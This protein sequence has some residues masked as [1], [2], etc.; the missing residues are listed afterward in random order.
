MSSY[1]N[2]HYS[3][4]KCTPY[5]LS[6][7]KIFLATFCADHK[8]DKNHLDI[9]CNIFDTSKQQQHKTASICLPSSNEKNIY[10]FVNDI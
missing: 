6:S 4:K 8:S 7:F 9:I 10:L 1:P 3:H 2:I 5:N